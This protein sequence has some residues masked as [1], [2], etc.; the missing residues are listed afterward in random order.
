MVV[1]TAEWSEEAETG[2]DKEEA[3]ARKQRGAECQVGHRTAQG[4]PKC[5]GRRGGC[6]VSAPLPEAAPSP[7]PPPP[8]PPQR[9]AQGSRVISCRTHRGGPRHSSAPPP[10]PPLL[11][12]RPG[13]QRDRPESEAGH[14]HTWP[15]GE[16]PRVPRVLRGVSR[17]TPP[18]AC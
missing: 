10:T 1:D 3:G 13:M 5:P 6:R 14:T 2:G 17:S 7:D 16:R 9:L 8:A 18:G 4:L 12:G 15:G 11:G